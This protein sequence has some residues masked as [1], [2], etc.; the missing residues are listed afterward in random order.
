VDRAS[1]PNDDNT[2]APV[3]GDYTVCFKCQAVLVFGVDMQLR[4]PTSK[5]ILHMPLLE[6]SQ[7]QRGF[8]K[9]KEHE[10]NEHTTT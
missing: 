8:K 6:I 2:E 9:L 4:H 3:P 10:D 7:I 1:N 5:E